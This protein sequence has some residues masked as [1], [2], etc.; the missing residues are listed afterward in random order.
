[1]KQCKLSFQ[2][3]TNY[4]SSRWI[5]AYCYLENKVIYAYHLCYG[6]E[7]GTAVST[8]SLERNRVKIENGMKKLITHQRKIRVK[9]WLHFLYMCVLLLRVAK[10]VSKL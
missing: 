2:T 5:L 10:T 9:N 6:F 7:V 8:F 4:K 1:M 3:F